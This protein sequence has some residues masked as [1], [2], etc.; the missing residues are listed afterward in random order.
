MMKF[1]GMCFKIYEKI[2]SIG[3]YVLFFYT[4]K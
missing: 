2:F 3:E 4:M 1:T